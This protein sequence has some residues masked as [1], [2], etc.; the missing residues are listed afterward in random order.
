MRCE[1]ISL[2][3]S[4]CRRIVCRC[5]LLKPCHCSYTFRPT[6]S[7]FRIGQS[8]CAETCGGHGMDCTAFNYCACMRR[9]LEASLLATI[10]VR[11][12]TL[13]CRCTV[14]SKGYCSSA[15]SGC[16]TYFCCVRRRHSRSTGHAHFSSGDFVTAC[17]AVLAALLQYHRLLLQGYLTDSPKKEQTCCAR[18]YTLTVIW[19][20]PVAP[21]PMSSSRYGHFRRFLLVWYPLSASHACITSP[22]LHCRV[23]TSTSCTWPAIC[24]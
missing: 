22:N 4:M 19:M 2:N 9:P 1:A 8:C 17:Q 3:T 6:S 12:S 5:F 24:L 10:W 16:A 18:C 15:G 7:Q 20:R 23:H 14:S 13:Q 21:L 11:P